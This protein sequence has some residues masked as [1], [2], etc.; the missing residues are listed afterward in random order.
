MKEHIALRFQVRSDT[1]LQDVGR[2]NMKSTESCPLIMY[3]S[4][5]AENCVSISAPIYRY[6]AK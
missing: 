6:S 2:E 1:T 4:N 3:L 5:G